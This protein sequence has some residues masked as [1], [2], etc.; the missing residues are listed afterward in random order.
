ME[1]GALAMDFCQSLVQLKEKF[2]DVSVN[3]SEVIFV[4]DALRKTF[5]S[6]KKPA[7]ASISPSTSPLRGILVSTSP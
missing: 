3:Q 7:D 1:D 5:P 4:S 2:L 6:F